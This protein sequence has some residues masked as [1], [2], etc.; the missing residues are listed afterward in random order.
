M[1]RE[2]LCRQAFTCV[3]RECHLHRP[4]TSQWCTEPHTRADTSCARHRKPPSLIQG[5]T[6]SFH[7]KGILGPGSS[8]GTGPRRTKW[9]RS[10]L[11]WQNVSF[12]PM[13]SAELVGPE[14]EGGL[15]LWTGL[16]S[17]AMEHWA[18][19]RLHKHF[20]RT[21]TLQGTDVAWPTREG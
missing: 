7:E 8:A 6:A 12:L 3:Q 1:W 20:P 18:W 2:A 10:H 21:P 5:L 4:H 11:P 13:V 19:L 14:Q 9:S 16:G 15:V 17:R